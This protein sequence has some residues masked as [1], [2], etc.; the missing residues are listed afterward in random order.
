MDNNLNLFLIE[1]KSKMKNNEDEIQNKLLE[2]KHTLKYCLNYIIKYEDVDMQD[3]EFI[4]EELLNFLKSYINI[5]IQIGKKNEKYLVID[6]IVKNLVDDVLCKIEPNKKEFK[7]EIKLIK[8]ER[9]KTSN[10]IK[11]FKTQD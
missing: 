8:K 11:I 7:K 10:T 9:N 5:N 3:S 1:N 4:R 6:S 2:T